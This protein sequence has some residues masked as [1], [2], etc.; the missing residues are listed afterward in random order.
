MIQMFISSV[1]TI[2][3]GLL[4]FLVR[5]ILITNVNIIEESML[6]FEESLD[7]SIDMMESLRAIR[8]S[9]FRT[10]YA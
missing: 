7:S 1:F 5:T 3:I 4:L 8:A 2:I 9:K 6:M 10:G